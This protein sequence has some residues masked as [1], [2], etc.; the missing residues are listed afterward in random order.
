AESLA[1]RG[2]PAIPIERA[3]R[4]FRINLIFEGS[5][6][7]MRLFIAREAVDYHFKL[8][9]NIVNPES[10]L[11]QKLSA[12]AKATPF[13]L[14]WYPTRWIGSRFTSSISS[15]R[16]IRRFTKSQWKCLLGSTRGSSRES[17][18]VW[19]RERNRGA[20]RRPQS[21]SRERLAGSPDTGCSRDCWD[22]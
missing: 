9:F 5:S 10:T 14:T 19:L 17:S 15:A 2:E 12:M 6:E 13:Y 16:T 21:R 20:N 7:I 4:D 3:M 8:A 22:C 18:R 11:K 1:R